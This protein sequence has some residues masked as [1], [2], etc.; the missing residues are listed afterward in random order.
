MRRREVA[1]ALKGEDHD[2]QAAVLRRFD[3]LQ[4]HQRQCVDASAVAVWTRTAKGENAPQVFSPIVD[5]E[6]RI[7]IYR[8]YEH[9]E[10]GPGGRARAYA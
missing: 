1:A 8:D 5:L 9:D 4:L 2:V 6:T 7:Q 10:R 3:S